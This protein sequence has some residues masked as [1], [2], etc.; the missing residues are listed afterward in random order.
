[1][2]VG[3]LFFLETVVIQIQRSNEVE[4]SNPS[5][6]DNQSGS[7]KAE[8]KL[9]AYLDRIWTHELLSRQ[10]G[11]LFGCFG[12]WFLALFL[13]VREVERRCKASAGAT[14]DAVKPPT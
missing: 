13:K 8:S 12:S 10:L 11:A 6:A 3:L 2:V 7:S 4:R 14:F 1:M 5:N 9:D